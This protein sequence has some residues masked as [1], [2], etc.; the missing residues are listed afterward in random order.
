MSVKLLSFVFLTAVVRQVKSTSCGKPY[1]QP[2]EVRIVGGRPAIEG[3][4]PW[5]AMLVELGDQVCGGSIIAD[6]LILSA[7]H[8]FEDPGSLDPSR[9][10]VRVGAYRISSHTRYES[11]HHVHKI[12]MHESYNTNTVENDVAIMVLSQRIQYNNGVMPICLPTNSIHVTEGLHCL[13]AGWGET[14]GTGSDDVLNQVFVP[15]LSD[16]TCQHND[17]YGHDFFPATSFCAGYP[18]G[19]KDSCSGDSGGPLVYKSGPT[20][21]QLGITSWGI[22]CAQPKKP[23]I[24]TDV[25]KYMPWIHH[26]ATLWQ[27]H[28]ITSNG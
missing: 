25:A 10:E 26:Q 21:Y 24:Y 15:V 13:S 1:V 8:C 12:I 9:W 28:I 16:S 17:W 5:M 14:R 20:W 27:A 2:H 6:N 7:A 18:Q 22:D 11:V 3:S 4:L 19:R 23:G